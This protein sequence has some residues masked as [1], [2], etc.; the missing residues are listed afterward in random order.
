MVDKLQKAITWI[1]VGGFVLAYFFWQTM[2]FE[3]NISL[4][5]QDF[6]AWVHV[7]FVL[8]ITLQI[9]N[10]GTDNGI[11]RGLASDEYKIAEEKNNGIIL[12]LSNELDKVIDYNFELNDNALKSEQ[13]L[14]LA[15]KGVK[16]YEELSNFLK[17]KYDRLKRKVKRHNISGITL[18]I[19][20][21]TIRGNQISYD[22]SYDGVGRKKQVFIKKV[23]SSIVT[24]FLG[25]G[26]TFAVNKLGDAVVKL[27]VV[28]LIQT[29]N[30]FLNFNNPLRMLKDILPKRVVQKSIYR[31]NYIE[32][33]KKQPKVAEAK[34]INLPLVIEEIKKGE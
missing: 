33:E 31:D 1:I 11:A 12:D 10:V 34:P 4:V 7:V 21:E 18:P 17:R 22:T 15:S 13:K 16:T 25:V 28:G 27:F 8:T 32:W 23:I 2:E 20:Y 30:Y 9:A 24:S 26:F 6:E 29:A 14:F 3:G 19:Y 5:V